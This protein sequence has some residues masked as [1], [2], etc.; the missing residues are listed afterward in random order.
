MNANERRQLTWLWEHR[1]DE[2]N[3]D[4]EQQITI[5]NNQLGQVID[6][7]AASGSGA[8]VHLYRGSV[9]EIAVAGEPIEWD[10]TYIPIAPLEF[11]VTLPVTEITIPK[12][13][14]YD[15]S[16]EARW[17]TYQGGG[18]IS[19]VVIRT[20]VETTVW[21]PAGS[22]T[23]VSTSAQE[24]TEETAPAIPLIAGDLIKVVIDH[25]NGSAQDLA[26][27]HIVLDLV[28][29]GTSATSLPGWDLFFD[30][31]D[32]GVTFDFDAS[33]WWTTDVYADPALFRRGLD[34]TI[35]DSY[36]HYDANI[37]PLSAAGLVYAEG[38]LWATGNDNTHSVVKIDPADGT[39][40]SRIAA[41][42][43]GDRGFQTVAYNGTNLFVVEAINNRIEEYTMAGSFVQNHSFPS[44]HELV[45]L[46]WDG[47][48]FWATTAA[49]VVLTM[50]PSFAVIADDPGPP[51]STTYPPDAGS[52]LFADCQ[53][54]DGFLYV[55]T[56][57]GLFRKAF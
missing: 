50:N 23:W 6:G 8:F 36:G 37:T 46:T 52:G 29:R 44:G 53:W 43:A 9:Q 21:P 3:S 18:T 24:F 1:I 25:G 26:Y 51:T 32:Y 39:V 34:G 14:Y 15:I 4:L 30:V 31:D 54:L 45:G 5:I 13:G 38:F 33:Q 2:A 19:V 28:D 7:G 40:D 10:T 17:D 56:A 20:G 57:E 27:A 22:T 47:V 35:I 55:C 41:N 12:S 48:N 16:I 49:G 11:N 42:G